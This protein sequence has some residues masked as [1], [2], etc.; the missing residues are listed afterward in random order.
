MHYT[1]EEEEARRAEIDAA[2]ATR[3]S[4]EAPSKTAG[5]VGS[6]AVATCSLPVSSARAISSLLRKASATY[7]ELGLLGASRQYSEFA[8]LLDA[9]ADAESAN[10]RQPEENDKAQTRAADRRT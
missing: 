6:L 7:W 5:P 3:S 8:D 9:N 2:K 1:H 10:V 4:A